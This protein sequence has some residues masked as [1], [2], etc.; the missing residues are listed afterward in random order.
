MPDALRHALIF[1]GLR[2]EDLP[3]D[4]VTLS[5]VIPAYNEIRTAET[6]LRRV[7]EVPLELEVIVV[8]DGSTDG[9]R[10]LLK[11]MEAEEEI[12]ETYKWRLIKENNLPVVVDTWAIIREILEDLQRGV[13]VPKISSKFHQT[14]ASF[15]LAVCESIREKEGLNKVVLTGGVF[16]NR[17]LLK[18][19][20][21]RLR[22][23]RFETFFHQ[24]VPTNDGGLALGQAAIACKQLDR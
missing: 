22:E 23:N 1:P 5:V 20:L 4:Q 17:L 18:K 19:V 11:E 21:H 6:L 24:M 2:D 15:S 9:T 16:Q 14:V 3:W 12:R 7:R 13:T 10:D 8:D